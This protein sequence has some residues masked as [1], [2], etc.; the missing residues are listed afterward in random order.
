M[1]QSVLKLECFTAVIPNKV[2]EGAKIL[3]SLKNA[4][5]NLVAFWGYPLGAKAKEAAIEM[6]P[7]T[8]VGFSAIARK[9][10][11]RVERGVAFV[12]LGDDKVGALAGVLGKLAAAGINVDAVKSIRAGKG[13]YAAG[14]FVDRADIRKAAKI[15][16]AK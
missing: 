15:L 13:K 5:V 9:A 10:G 16:R 4:G 12:L 6:I 1:A 14:I 8:A 11:L 7:Q 3:T 2:G